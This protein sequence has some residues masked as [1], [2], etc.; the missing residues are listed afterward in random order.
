MTHPSNRQHLP[1]AKSAEELERTIRGLRE[2]L[3]VAGRYLAYDPDPNSA[4]AVVHRAL[5]RYPQAPEGDK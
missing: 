4:F 5:A 3:E 1:P 2:A